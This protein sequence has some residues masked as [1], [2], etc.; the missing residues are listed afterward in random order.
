VSGTPGAG[1][2]TFLRNPPALP[3]NQ[4]LEKHIS[5]LRKWKYQLALDPSQQL[6]SVI[7]AWNT[8]HSYQGGL[9]QSYEESKIS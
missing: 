2:L 4:A 9:R 5:K 6:E 7:T 8:K 3:K 1:K